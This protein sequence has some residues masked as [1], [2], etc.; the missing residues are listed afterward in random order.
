[1]ITGYWDNQIVDFI[2]NYNESEVKEPSVCRNPLK[3]YE[4][5]LD[6]ATC[7]AID[8]DGEIYEFEEEPKYDNGVW[9]SDERFRYI[10]TLIDFD[11]TLS[12][13][14]NMIL[15]RQE[16]KKCDM[17]KEYEFKNI[18]SVYVTIDSDGS[19]AE[20]DIKPTY[21][22]WGLD[23]WRRGWRVLLHS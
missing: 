3:G 10:E 1:M 14:S 9:S 5:K 8:I 17:L 22:K 11:V 18:D 2:K 13:C 12:D 7:V 15:Y 19:V 16:Y 21:R 23:F 20:W 4:F 6:W